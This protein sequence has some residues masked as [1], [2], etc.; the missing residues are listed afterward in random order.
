MLIDALGNSNPMAA[1]T[2]TMAFSEARLRVIADNV[3][4]ANTPGFRARQL[5]PRSFQA[6][7]AEALAD[8]GGDETRPLCLD[9]E[10]VR[11]SVA[12]LLET[13]PEELP[14][15]NILFH[16]GTNVSIEKEMA[17]LAET[18]MTYEFAAT[19]LGQR[20]DGLR[21]AIRGTL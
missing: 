3:A 11:T 2:A 6:T 21:K 12:G 5:D 7:L 19:M 9:G 1:L 4:N 15:E 13:R 14:V 18:S 8:R 20:F 17:A 10:Q 16:D